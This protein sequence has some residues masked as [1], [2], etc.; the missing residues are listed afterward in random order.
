MHIWCERHI[1]IALCQYSFPYCWMEW[2]NIFAY[3]KSLLLKNMFFCKIEKKKCFERWRASGWESCQT[4]LS[5]SPFLT[6]LSHPAHF[7]QRLFVLSFW[8]EV[9]F[10]ILTLSFSNISGSILRWYRR[11]MKICKYVLPSGICALLQRL[12]RDEPIQIAS[13]KLQK[14]KAGSK[15]LSPSLHPN[16][17]LLSRNQFWNLS[18]HF[19]SLN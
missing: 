11:G 8:M 14:P 19:S 6:S 10:L 9:F 1:P 16:T 17:V 4:L 18:G 7:C 2:L 5:T 15:L 12:W 13:E 3:H